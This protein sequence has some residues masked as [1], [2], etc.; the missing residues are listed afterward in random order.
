[1][2]LRINLV[3]LSVFSQNLLF[4]GNDKICRWNE[5]HYQRRRIEYKISDR[6]KGSGNRFFTSL[7]LYTN[8][9]NLQQTIHWTKISALLGWQ[10][11]LQKMSWDPTT[12]RREFHVQKTAENSD[13]KITKFAY[14][15]GLCHGL[16]TSSGWIN[17]FPRVKLVSLCCY[18]Q[19]AFFFFWYEEF[20]ATELARLKHLCFPSHNGP[21]CCCV[22]QCSVFEIFN[23][24]KRFFR[25]SFAVQTSGL[26]LS[27]RLNRSPAT[28]L[29]WGMQEITTCGW[30]FRISI[31]FV[32]N[33]LN[34]RS[35][36]P[37]ETLSYVRI[38]V[39]WGKSQS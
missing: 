30:G 8:T 13:R 1:M 5:Q 9:R 39:L 24:M 28:L 20:S 15:F 10:F 18:Q 19:L 16:I 32:P 38:F 22:W 26:N 29:H 23:G 34:N 31:S 12:P 7:Y 36:Q 27:S 35:F 4:L 11:F 2:S 6:P 25:F 14:F 21:E 33:L 37:L 17:T 3:V